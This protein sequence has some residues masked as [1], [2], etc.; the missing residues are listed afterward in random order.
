MPTFFS[1]LA[2]IWASAVALRSERLPWIVPVYLIAQCAFALTAFLG[3][4]KDILFSRFYTRFF[5]IAFA[6]VL[7]S[8]LAF[9]TQQGLRAPTM[10]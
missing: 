2:L 8:A 4:Q 9:A 5:F 3:L 1:V 7:V 10:G 6:I